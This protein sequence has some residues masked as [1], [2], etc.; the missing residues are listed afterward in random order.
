MPHPAAMVPDT[1]ATPNRTLQSES[2]R[3]NRENFVNLPARENRCGPGQ[4]EQKGTKEQRDKILRTCET[5]TN[6]E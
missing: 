1:E 5:V 4:G 3:G 6:I 2:R